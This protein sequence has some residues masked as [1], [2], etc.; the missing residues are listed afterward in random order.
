MSA[1]APGFVRAVALTG[2]TAAG[3][4]ALMEAMLL[5]AG[6][7]ERRSSGASDAVGDASPEARARAHSVE[8]NIANF[9]FLGDR[10]AVIDCP[11]AVD[12]AADGD[13]ALPVVDLAVV[14]ADP[15]PAKAILL[16]PVLKELERLGVPRL[17]FVNK[18]DQA[19]GALSDLLAAFSAVSAVPMVARQLPI[20]TDDHVS[21]FVD[22]ALERAFAYREGRPSEPIEPSTAVWAEEADA[23]F[24]MLEQLADFDDVLMEQLLSDETPDRE[25]IFG[26][27]VREMNEGLIMPVLFGARA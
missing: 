17:L 2:P 6:A 19:R 26:V 10:Y 16:Q 22:L 21:G 14:V 1:H 11:G 8:L 24:H 3:K 18:M 27:L 23:R 13:F 12:F 15:D 5:D 25:M 9:E 7:V 20:W 4:T